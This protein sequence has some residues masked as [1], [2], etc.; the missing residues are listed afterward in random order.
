VISEGTSNYDGASD[1]CPEN[2]TFDAPRIALQNT[3]LYDAL[4]AENNN[5][6]KLIWIDL[7]LGF[8]AQDCWVIGKYG[9]CWWLNQVK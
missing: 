1:A 9:S 4:L 5:E 2:Y 7:N 8:P 6:D 3:I